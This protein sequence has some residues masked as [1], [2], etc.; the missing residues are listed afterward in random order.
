M[1]KKQGET[2][3]RITAVKK[4]RRITAVRSKENYCGKEARRITV[5]KKQGELL[6]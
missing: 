5:V 1:V 3:R 2:A 4:P 6:W